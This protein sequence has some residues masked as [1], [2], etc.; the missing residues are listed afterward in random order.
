MNPHPLIS[1][2]LMTELNRERTRTATASRAK[3]AGPKSDRRAMFP[4]GRR[5]HHAPSC[6][7][8]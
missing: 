6:P 4:R 5:R 2:T 3:P 1:Y 7:T 8:A